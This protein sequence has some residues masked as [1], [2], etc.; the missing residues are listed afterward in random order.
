MNKYQRFNKPWRK[1]NPALWQKSKRENYAK[2]RKHAHNSRARWTLDEVKRLAL[3]DAAGMLDR[4]IAK[5]LGRSVQSIQIKRHK[6]IT[7]KSQ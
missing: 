4:A 3:L 5:E 6:L 1:S 7:G 2:G